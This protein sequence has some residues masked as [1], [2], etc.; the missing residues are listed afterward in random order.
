MSEFTATIGDTIGVTDAISSRLFQASSSTDTLSVADRLQ[1]AL[2]AAR[3]LTDTV[4]IADSLIAAISIA[5]KIS[6]VRAFSETRIRIDFERPATINTAL[7]RASSYRF[8][9]VSSGSVEVVPLSVS[10]PP[11]Q[12]NPLYVEIETT[13]HTNE[14]DY[15]VALT[16]SIRGAAGEVGS[17]VPVPY[18]GIGVSPKLKVV[19]AVSATEVEVHFDE[20]IENNAEAN[21]PLNYTWTGGLSTIAVRSVV[22]NVVTLQTTSQIPGQLY[23][24]TVEDPKLFHSVTMQDAVDAVDLLAIAAAYFFKKTLQDSVDTADA[25]S[26]ACSYSF[27][28]PTDFV[29]VSDLGR[30]SLTKSVRGTDSIAITDVVLAEGSDDDMFWAGVVTSNTTITSGVRQGYNPTASTFTLTAPGSPLAGAQFAVLETGGST[31]AITVSGNGVNIWDP[32]AEAFAA[33]FTI[34]AAGVSLHW[35]YNGTAWGLV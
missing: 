27:R 33:S 21:D 14:A 9:N 16:S 1:S 26:I 34:G 32:V 29:S 11:G 18:V 10:L 5:L 13:E 31:R 30:T 35:V 19:L 23:S 3:R 4:A 7:T 24:L 28:I 22:A 12:A 6:Q 15:E 2:N 25:V 8:T 17:T 20:P